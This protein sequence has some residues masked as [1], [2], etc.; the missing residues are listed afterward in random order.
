VVVTFSAYESICRFGFTRKTATTTIRIGE[1]ND[2]YHVAKVL[3]SRALL[4]V[5]F[6]FLPKKIFYFAVLVFNFKFLNEST[7]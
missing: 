5:K 4:Q 2:L 7:K 6:L 3:A 1:H